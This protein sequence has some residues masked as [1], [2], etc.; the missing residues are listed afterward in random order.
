MKSKHKSRFVNS[1]KWW[2]YS[3]L[4]L[5]MEDWLNN[6]SK[7]FKTKGCHVGSEKQSKQMKIAASLIKRIREDE[8][9]DKPN[10]VFN[11]RNVSYGDL[12]SEFTSTKWETSRSQRLQDLDY[13]FKFM[14][15]NMFSWWD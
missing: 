3:Y 5:A 13:L 8:V 11:N 2:D 12:G 10:K 15:R 4:L 6:S 1:Y 9:Y 14:K 7:E